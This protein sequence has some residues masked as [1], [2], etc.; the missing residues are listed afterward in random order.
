MAI[1]DCG[2]KRFYSDLQQPFSESNGTSYKLQ[3]K[4]AELIIYIQIYSD[5][6]QPF[7]ESNGIFSNFPMALID[8]LFIYK[9]FARF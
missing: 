4:T 5:L 9:I 1:S 6:K 3:S 8:S 7:S 2:T